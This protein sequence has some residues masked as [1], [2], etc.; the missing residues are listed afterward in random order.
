MKKP[1]RLLSI[2]V[3]SAFVITGCA[4]RSV[5]IAELK[6]Q[7]D[8]YEKKTVSVTGVVTNSFGI[9]L[10]P[11]QLYSVDDGSGE[12][13]I[14]SQSGRSPSKGSR[15]QVKGKVNELGV[16]GGRSIGLHLR[17]DSRKIKG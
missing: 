12:I 5:R 16:F 2:A 3:L 14:V 9:P 8:K 15:V 11:F 7:P 1:T 10:V 6:G 17:E 13:T 4:A